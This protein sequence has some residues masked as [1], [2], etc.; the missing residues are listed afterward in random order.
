MAFAVRIFSV[1]NKLLNVK[2]RTVQIATFIRTPRSLCMHRKVERPIVLKIEEIVFFLMVFRMSFEP[3][4]D[5]VIN[6][7]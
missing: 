4:F 2:N 6:P 1:E 3:E 7:S 5:F